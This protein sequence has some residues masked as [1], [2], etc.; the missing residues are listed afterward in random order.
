MLMDECST[1]GDANPRA[2]RIVA[3]ADCVDGRSPAGVHPGTQHREPEQLRDDP[4]RLPEVVPPQ[5]S[6]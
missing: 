2:A 4:G 6:R 3:F 1:G 5:S